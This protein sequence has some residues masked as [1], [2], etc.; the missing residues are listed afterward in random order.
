MIKERTFM[1]TANKRAEK[2]LLAFEDV[3]KT[4]KRDGK[5]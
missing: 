5:I 4:L 2:P 1:S 3:V